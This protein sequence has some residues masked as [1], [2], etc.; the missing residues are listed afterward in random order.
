MKTPILLVEDDAKLRRTLAAWIA[1]A[2]YDVTEA[3]DGETAVRLLMRQQFTVIVSDLVMGA[4]D[5]LGVLQAAARQPDGP[6][7]ILLTGQG[8]LESAMAALRTGAFDYLLKPCNGHELLAR[9][10]AAAEQTAAHRQV[11]A[12]IEQLLGTAYQTPLTLSALASGEPFR[13]Q[14]ARGSGLGTPAMAAPRLAAR[15]VPD[16][17]EQVI[18]LGE[19]E[20]GPSRLQVLF[21][22]KPVSLTRIEYALLRHLAEQP[23]QVCRYAD[24]A[25]SSHRLAM[26]DG[27]A[28][29][30]LRTHLQNLRSKICRSYFQLEPGAGCMLAVPTLAYGFAGGETP[31]KSASS[32]W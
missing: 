28:R 13:S 20:V 27:E 9:I 1:H 22:G 18:R 21:Q 10:A 8:T 2:G 6:A 25:F 32:R 4:I 24:L 7:V 31:K 15:S 19:L 14:G 16:Q 23:G 30:L 3:P 26:E 12:A 17:S 29:D 11:R 5:G